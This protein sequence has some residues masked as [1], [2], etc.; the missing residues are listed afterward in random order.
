MNGS[1]YDV[2][3]QSLKQKVDEYSNVTTPNTAF[4]L[5][6]Y[7]VGKYKSYIVYGA[8]PLAVGILLFLIKPGFIM[9]EKEGELGSEY[10][11]KMDLSKL[12]TSSIIISTALAICVGVY[13]Y[14]KKSLTG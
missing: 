9:I 11:T 1:E 3:I 10:E 2:T 7:Q 6:P 13:F 4:N 14:K 8:I 5:I 12:C